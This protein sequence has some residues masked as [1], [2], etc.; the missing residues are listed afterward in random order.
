MY[1]R[2]I[3]FPR[4][5]IE[6]HGEVGGTLISLAD[7]LLFNNSLIRKS[8]SFLGGA[9]FININAQNEKK[10]FFRIEN[11]FFEWNLG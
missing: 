1:D 11:S 7:R 9:M 4:N 5:V 3:N 10:L 2:K 6:S 8:G